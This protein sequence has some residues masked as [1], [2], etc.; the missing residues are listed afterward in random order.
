MASFHSPT[1]AAPEL[2]PVDVNNEN[3]EQPNTG[4]KRLSGAYIADSHNNCIQRWDAATN[5][6]TTVV[7]QVFNSITEQET[8][9]VPQAHVPS[10]RATVGAI[11]IDQQS[12]AVYYT[13]GAV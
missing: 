13:A 10:P 9:P 3:T 4:I 7:N 2:T 8:E 5:T 6:V 12:R 1:A 11:A